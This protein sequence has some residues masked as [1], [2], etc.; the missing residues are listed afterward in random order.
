MTLWKVSTL[1]ESWTSTE[2]CTPPPYKI[3]PLDCH[4]LSCKSHIFSPIYSDSHSSIQASVIAKDV[5][6]TF[7]L[8]WFDKYTQQHKVYHNYILLNHHTYPF[9]SNT[10]LIDKTTYTV[11]SSISQIK[12]LHDFHLHNNYLSRLYIRI[13]QPINQHLDR[14]QW[15]HFIYTYKLSH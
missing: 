9:R 12:T 5:T 10:F 4:I 2:S 8:L 3:I 6:V 11:I 7:V 1:E 15:L 14:L 13:N